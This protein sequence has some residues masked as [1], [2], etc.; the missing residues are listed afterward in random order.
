MA[1]LKKILNYFSSRNIFLEE[2]RKLEELKKQHLSFS[3]D[4]RQKLNDNYNCW[5]GYYGK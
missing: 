2:E 3:S 5:R 4:I 1:I